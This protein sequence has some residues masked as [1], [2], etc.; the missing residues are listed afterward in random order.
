MLLFGGILIAIIILLC[1][2]GYS[3]FVIRSK[4]P[5]KENENEQVKKLI[6]T[7]KYFY[8]FNNILSYSKKFIE[9]EPTLTFDDSFKANSREKLLEMH[10]ENLQERIRELERSSSL[11]YSLPIGDKNGVETNKPS[12][13]T[14]PVTYTSAQEPSPKLEIVS[15]SLKDQSI[16]PVL[17]AEQSKNR[18]YE[19]VV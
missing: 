14:L 10:I 7:M 4:R 5:D 15:H 2:N 6:H 19:T 17:F 12:F 16:I 18:T 11:L 9:Y 13:L 8:F 1:E 3:Q